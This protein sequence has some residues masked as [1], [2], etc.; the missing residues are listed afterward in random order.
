M[1]DRDP[2]CL[3]CKIVAGEVPATIVAGSS[4]ATILQNRQSG[5]RSAMAGEPIGPPAAAVAPRGAHARC[6]APNC[7]IEGKG[8]AAVVVER[9]P[10][11]PPLAER[12]R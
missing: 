1:A 7:I 3:F 12:G 8:V 5:S 4:P 10:R 11:S 2:D 9:T 6:A